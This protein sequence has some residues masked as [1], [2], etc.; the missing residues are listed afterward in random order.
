M[1]HK[2]FR[3]FC[4]VIILAVLWSTAAEA[5]SF[6]EWK[7]GLVA[8]AQKE[9]IRNKTIRHYLLG[10]HANDT[11]IKLDKKQPEGTLGYAEYRH[12]GAE[13]KVARGR[14]ML[15]KYNKLLNE[16]GKAYGVDPEV[17]V[18]LWGMETTYGRNSG[19]ISTIDALATL[20]YEGRR[21]EFFTTELL[22]LLKLIDKGEINPRRLHGSWAGAMG[23][24]QFM[25]SSFVK[26][27]VDY[28]KN[29][30]KD[31]WRSEADI[32]ASI[33]NYLK[34]EG[35]QQNSISMSYVKLPQNFDHKSADLGI[36]KSVEEWKKLNVEAK[37]WPKDGKTQGTI[38][39][40][41][42]DKFTHTV[43][44]YNNFRI[45]LKW[46]YSRLFAGAALYLAQEIK[47]A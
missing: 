32:F 14:K 6:E 35:W 10:A 20:A 43:L 29:G 24:T 13:P 34:T 33:A 4:N 30:K 45:L 8:R 39:A 11:V 7:Q 12:V 38:L 42:R 37:I 9:G 1:K 26:Y 18:A 44:V 40:L 25:P 15:K 21:S 27:A 22:T 36:S 16:I 17:I 23:Q 19:T 46:N 41:D 28:D 47:K 3:L 5:K 2:R 31:I